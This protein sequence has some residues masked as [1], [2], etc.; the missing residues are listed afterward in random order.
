MTVVFE[1]YED[2]NGIRANIEQ[3]KYCRTFRLVIMQMI[4]ECRASVLYQNW[5]TTIPN[6]R[7]AM[8]RQLTKPVRKTFDVHDKVG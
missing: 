7:R 8:R 2:A 3:D 5:Y 4:D 1:S 6:A